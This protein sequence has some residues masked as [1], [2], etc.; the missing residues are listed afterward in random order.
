MSMKSTRGVQQEDVRQAADLLIAEGLRPTIER[1]RQKMGR[2]SPNT[3]GPLLDVWFASL[4]G[5]L[6]LGGQKDD[7]QA[8]EPVQQAAVMLWQTAL[9]SAREDA[10]LAMAQEQQVLRQHQSAIT[11]Q[12]A[13]LQHQQEVLMAR[14]HAVDDA[15]QVARSQLA[16]MSARLD[17][18]VMRLDLRDSDIAVL[19]DKLSARE[20]ERD[21]SLLT[22]EEEARRHAEERSRLEARASANERRLLEGLDRERQEIKR[23]KTTLAEVERCAEATRL[24]LEA[25]S[26]ALIIK[27]QATAETLQAE[28]QALASAKLRSAEL[29][30]LLEVQ[31]LA[32]ETQL[33]QLNLLL[34][35]SARK[36]LLRASIRRRRI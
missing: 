15:L 5:R 22:R 13:D 7:R 33:K 30:E 8:P 20:K 11:L 23:L 6:G 16:D 17:E 26:S 10:M 35:N 4:A 28:Q 25:A 9:Q 21:A 27:V 2:G 31:K 1:V 36:P 24:R 3:V 29:L 18:A 32:H 12:E 14:Q 19:R 34:V